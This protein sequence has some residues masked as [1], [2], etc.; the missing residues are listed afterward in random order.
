MAN[1]TEYTAIAT[2]LIQRADEIKATLDQNFVTEQYLWSSIGHPLTKDVTDKVLFVMPNGG[3]YRVIACP[4][5]IDQFVAKF[6]KTLKTEDRG[7]SRK[8][9]IASL[10]KTGDA[11]DAQAQILI[12]D[13]AVKAPR[14][15]RAPKAPRMTAVKAARASATQAK[16][17]VR[18]INAAAKAT[19]TATVKLLK[20]WIRAEKETAQI[21]ARKDK[22]VK[23][24]TKVAAHDAKA[25]QKE[26]LNVYR[27]FCAAEKAAARKAKAVK[28]AAKIAA[29]DTKVK[30]A[31]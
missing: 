22:A 18:A 4:V 10:L 13:G 7:A 2:Y 15:P 9:F 3:R 31:K 20:A 30:N 29:H 11:E 26:A 21:D 14:K 24:A 12:E 5:R 27:A 8:A 19:I 25:A 23:A 17:T 16:R 6:L 28:A 1:S